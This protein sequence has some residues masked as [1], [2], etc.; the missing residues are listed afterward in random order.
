[1]PAVRAAPSF[2]RVF[3][4]SVIFLIPVVRSFD[5]NGFGD[6][7]VD[8]RNQDQAAGLLGEAEAVE[9]ERLRGGRDPDRVGQAV[10]LQGAFGVAVEAAQRDRLAA[11]AGR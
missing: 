5:R 3:D 10:I 1:M 11:G 2:P 4:V 7:V 8:G 9:G 6:G